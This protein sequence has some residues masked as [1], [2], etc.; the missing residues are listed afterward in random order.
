MIDKLLGNPKFLKETLNGL[1]KDSWDE[2]DAWFL[3]AQSDQTYQVA[4]RYRWTKNIL[5]WDPEKLGFVPEPEKRLA[6]VLSFAAKNLIE[7]LSDKT[8]SLNKMYYALIL[9][10]YKIRPIFYRYLGESSSAAWDE[11][12]LIESGKRLKD[13]ET[14]NQI[15]YTFDL[16]ESSKQYL[17][18][19]VENQRTVVRSTLSNYINEGVK[20]LQSEL[21]GLVEELDKTT[22]Q[23]RE[24]SKGTTLNLVEKRKP[25]TVNEKERLSVEPQVLRPGDKTFDLEFKKAVDKFND[26]VIS[27]MRQDSSVYSNN[28]IKIYTEPYTRPWINISKVTEQNRILYIG[29]AGIGKYPLALQIVAV[30][31]WNLFSHVFLFANDEIVENLNTVEDLYE[32]WATKT[33]HRILRDVEPLGLGKVTI[34][35]DNFDKLDDKKKQS[36][37]KE[38]DRVGHFVVFSRHFET[39]FTNIEVREISGSVPHQVKLAVLDAQEVNERP[40]TINYFDRFQFSRLMINYLEPWEN[41]AALID[42]ISVGGYPSLSEIADAV[43][44]DRLGR[45]NKYISMRTIITRLLTLEIVDL[46]KEEQGFSL[47]QI[48]KRW[49]RVVKRTTDLDKLAEYL[50]LM[51]VIHK[52]E[53]SENY[54]ITNPLIRD[55]LLYSRL[56]TKWLSGDTID[57]FEH[58]Q[59]DWQAAVW[60][61]DALSV[62]QEYQT[63]AETFL[64]FTDHINIQEYQY[65]KY[66]SIYSILETLP[67]PLYHQQELQTI[68]EQMKQNALIGQLDRSCES[69]SHK[70]HLDFQRFIYVPSEKVSRLSKKL[71]AILIDQKS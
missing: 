4:A 51:G 2:N 39:V 6:A 16:G 21:K 42:L 38:L 60:F 8:A 65:D 71:G 14:I 27:Y 61:L 36:S 25:G 17:F 56:I 15:I 45:D 49:D 23:D 50:E 52:L 32:H 34:V 22:D 64:A 28:Q 43:L 26:A 5:N 47:S 29:K 30:P 62:R 59:I 48:Q 3:I 66:L 19:A 57:M 24:I 1:L 46:V 69:E 55:N 31:D 18:D 53:T 11:P 44:R 9:I 35:L 7:E 10:V 41:G 67:K 68:I 63:A 12:T 37:A 40:N 13:P 70:I 58:W 33:G 54:Q 20:F